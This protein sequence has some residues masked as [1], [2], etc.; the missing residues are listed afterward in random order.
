MTA[1]LATELTKGVQGYDKKQY[2]GDVRVH[3]ISPVS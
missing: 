1:S 3:T 2:P